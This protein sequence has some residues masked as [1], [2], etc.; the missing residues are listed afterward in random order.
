MTPTELIRV[1]LQDMGLFP[2]VI[3]AG[4]FI[5]NTAVM[6]VQKIS[7]GRFKGQT[8]TMAIGF[9]EDS[10]PEYPPHFI[11]VADLPDSNIPIHS[12]FEHDNRQWK[13][14]SVPPSDIWDSLPESE[15]NMR[16]FINLHLLRFWNQI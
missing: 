15:K 11:Y 9:Q 7:T 4:D 5:Q 6:L 12:S 8:F 13:A 1:E 14:F 2:E 10:Y 3:S 16:T